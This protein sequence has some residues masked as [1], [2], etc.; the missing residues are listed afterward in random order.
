MLRTPVTLRLRQPMSRQIFRAAAIE[1]LST[2]E[3]LDTLLRVTTTRSWIALAALIAVVGGA[4]SW[5]IFGRTPEAVDASGIMLREDGLFR[6]PAHGTGPVESL[7]VYPGDHVRAGEVVAV[8]AQY[9]MRLAVQHAESTLAQ[10]RAHRSRSVPLIDRNRD[11][12]RAT[13]AERQEQADGTIAASRE[14]LTYLDG[15]IAAE[16]A[17]LAKGLITE[18]VL[19]NTIALRAATDQDVDAAKALKRELDARAA[20]IA[21]ESERE[22]FTLDQEIA[23]QERQVSAQRDQLRRAEQVISTYSGLVVE[24]LVDPGQLVQAGAPVATIEEET[25]PLE[26]YLFVADEGRRIVPGMRVELLPA[27]IK[28]EEHGHILGAVRSVSQGPMSGLALNRYL[29]NEALTERFSSGGG[30]YLVDVTE[31][32]DPRTPS[33]FKWSS[34]QGPKLRF[35]SGTL[36]SGRIVVR[37]QRPIELVIPALRRLFGV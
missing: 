21:T 22:R 30:V 37:E 5:G 32:R 18:D 13:I 27:G 28:S 19:Q 26:A 15:R 31:Q 14:R 6:I 11:L 10:L 3:R 29:Q 33:G 35:G 24:Q 8:V 4:L 23:V 9:D 2:P 1:R 20:S 25:V 17:A 34:R 36:L 16:R 12:E 7:S